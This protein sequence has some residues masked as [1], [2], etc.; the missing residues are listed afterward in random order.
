MR[1]F[2][3]LVFFEFLHECIHV[4]LIKLKI[5]HILQQSKAGENDPL[6]KYNPVHASIPSWFVW[7]FLLPGHPACSELAGLSPCPSPRVP[8]FLLS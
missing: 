3:S 8:S 5:K 6:T 4:L 1:T 2:A 7:V